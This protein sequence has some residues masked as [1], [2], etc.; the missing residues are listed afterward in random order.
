MDLYICTR[1]DV[2]YPLMEVSMLSTRHHLFPLFV[3][4]ES[5]ILAVSHVSAAEGHRGQ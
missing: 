3:L 2:D 4:A 1:G 5:Q